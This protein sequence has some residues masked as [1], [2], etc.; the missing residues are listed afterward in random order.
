MLKIF[1]RIILILIL[2]FILLVF[3]IRSPWGQSIIVDKVTNYVTKK[4][5]TTFN[6]DKLFITFS[7]NI[8]LEGLYI[9]DEVGDTLVYSKKL[10]ADIPLWPIIKGNSFSL[11]YLK[12][13]GAKANLIRKDSINGFNYQF[14]I[15]AFTTADTTQTTAKNETSIDIFIG[16]IDVSEI[17][18][19]YKDSVSGIDAQLNLG[20]LN[21]K[22]DLFDL[23][24]M[25]FEADVFKI[26]NT[27]VQLTQTKIVTT[28]DTTSSILPNF[29]IGE[30]ELNNVKASYKSSPQ[31]LSAKINLKEFYAEIPQVNLE[32]QILNLD[33]LVLNNSIVNIQLPKS[34]T[35]QTETTNSQ[36][37]S[38]QEIW[39][40]WRVNVANI[41]WLDNQILFKQGE[42]YQQTNQ[43]NPQN[44][45]I[46]HFNFVAEDL[47]LTEN[48]TANIQVNQFQFQENVSDFKLNQLSFKSSLKRDSFTLENIKIATGNSQLAGNLSAKYSSLDEVLKNMNSVHLQT[49][50]HTIHLDLKDIFKF[51]P[52]LKSNL[53]LQ[54]LSSV[55]ING[56]ITGSGNL[57]NLKVNSFH[58][59]WNNTHIS[60][61]G[62]LQSITNVDQLQLVLNNINIT[63]TR[64]DLVNF[65]D[66]KELGISIPNTVSLTGNVSGGLSNIK[67]NAKLLIPEGRVEL[68]G[69]YKNEKKTSFDA[70]LKTVELDLGKLLQNESLGKISAEIKTKGDGDH[71]NNLNA[72]LTSSFT[73]L[74]YNAY[75]LSDLK[76]S[77][78]ITNGTGDVDLVFKDQNI[79]LTTKATVQLDSVKPKVDFNVDLQGIDLLA[80]GISNRDIRAK[81]LLNGT[82]QGAPDYFTVDAKIE[83]AVAVYEESPY[84]IGN[85]NIHSQIG[86]DSTAVTV[87]GGFIDS[88]LYSNASPADFLE[89]LERHATHYFKTPKTQDSIKKPVNI[90]FEI[91]ITDRPII[92]DVL[93]EGIKEMDSIHLLVDFKEADKILTA[94]FSIPYLNYN[95]N[96]LDSLEFK[97]NSTKESANFNLGFQG[98]E[99]EPLAIEKTFF[100]GKITKD[101]LQLD[102]NSVKGEDVLYH[103]SSNISGKDNKI[104]FSINPNRLILNKNKWEVSSTNFVE[105]GDNTINFNQFSFSRNNQ[106]IAFKNNYEVEAPHMGVT[107]QDFKL[108]TIL[109]YF[110]QDQY[111]SSGLMKGDFVIV[112]P[113]EDLGLIAD[114]DIQ[115]FKVTDVALG[116]LAIDAS[117]KGAG[118]YDLNL[119]LLGEQIDLDLQGDY[120]AQTTAAKLDFD[121]NISKLGL[122]LLE[123]FFE[124]ELEE[125]KGDLTAQINISGTTT[126]PKYSGEFGFKNTNFLV[127]KLNSK[128][129]IS[130]E[131]IKLD[132]N[133]VNFSRFSVLDENNNEFII[134]GD[135]NTSE[136]LI[137]PTFNL[138]INADN[139]QALNSTAEDNDLYYGKAIFDLRAKLAGKL[140][141]PKL[142]LNFTVKKDTDVTYVLPISQVGI[143]E[144]DGVVVF[145]NKENPDNIL[146]KTDENEI[147][148]VLAG[149]ELT[150]K[151]TVEDGATFNVI[152]DKRTGDNLKLIGD[153]NLLFNIDRSGRTTLSG[154]YRINDGHYEMNLYGLVKRKFNIANG[155]TITWTG[156]PMNADL[157]VKAIYALET[158]ASSLMAS[159]TSSSSSTTQD[160]YRQQLSFLVYL[161][162][163]GEL[164]QPELNFGLD[165]PEE[166]QGA[167][168]GTVYTVVNQINEQEDQLNKQVFSLLVL[169]RFYPESGSDGSSGGV[170][171]VARD[172][173]N[174]AL[175]DQLNVF[176][177]K[178]T[179]NTGIQLN[180]GLDSY[181]DYQGSSPQD[182]TDL[183]VSAQ[184]NLFDDR[185][186]V[187]AGSDI[188][189]QGEAATGE[190]NPVIGNVSIEY[191]LTEDGRWRLKGFRKSSYENIIDGQVFVNGIALIFTREFNE[192]KELF[193]KSALEIKQEEREKKKENRKKNKAN[194]KAKEE[195]EN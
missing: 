87:K 77:G 133:G 123:Q 40:S 91:N 159:Q 50:L 34:E 165:M 31:N 117:S 18:F 195:E 66:E 26:E 185:L 70:E 20:N 179:G 79:D 41:S 109:G 155:S 106:K 69:S 114:L 86:Q 84:Y 46:E 128:F 76:L 120:I 134:R 3:F 168:N 98:I 154:R 178:L 107:F 13:H 129:S 171:T 137:D 78:N 182:R 125:T 144:R 193:N 60:T 89:A 63:S 17:N 28:V 142:D 158:S 44:F 119:A 21:Y 139:F 170:E 33:Q 188:G 49:E 163:G 136:S 166:D 126:E 4:T 116:D 156:D 187:K 124:G 27:T 71:I 73:K 12:W 59:N 43:F 68:V 30:V 51:N 25:N 149:V 173:L 81:L 102:F 64:K 131:K 135:I 112:N 147:S 176:S 100:E 94:N 110:N 75:D 161:N 62:T 9:E 99:A 101:T 24:K 22:G 174:Q 113:F 52:D 95:D 189:L 54:Q 5:N 74:T 92:S 39:P 10:E 115:D 47:V 192:F 103:I 194:N 141:F 167:I 15:D 11:D 180:F 2:L 121:L 45:D 58:L 29:R 127:T 108:S 35:N 1:S 42:I 157:D 172:N 164:L 138:K 152:I 186:I 122:P 184:K 61:N 8:N 14:L 148:A 65:V 118:N 143:N 7:G 132:N 67:A 150:S 181:T 190:E 85:I 16:N 88:K 23:E 37:L 104:H 96:K 48:Q 83:E 80:L 140:S 162:V 191:L 53:Y 57:E 56:T 32:D 38:I 55:P 82:Y 145:V 111:L 19:T 90:Y 72:E 183:S 130:D 93:A 153:A 97:L 151:L 36:N 169:N 177:D 175:S 105:F 6:I 146:T 160:Q